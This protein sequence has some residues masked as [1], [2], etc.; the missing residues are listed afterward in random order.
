MAAP[1]L[2]INA[3]CPAIQIAPRNAQ[4]KIQA[5]ANLMECVIPDSAAQMALPMRRRAF[6]PL[7]VHDG[8]QE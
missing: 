4:N 2:E 5:L 3:Y 1:C 6:L 7:S 8:A